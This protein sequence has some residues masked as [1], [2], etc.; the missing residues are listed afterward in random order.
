MPTM[1][2]A[3]SP[4]LYL[5]ASAID[6]MYLGTDKIYPNKVEQTISGS[7]PMTFTGDG[8]ALT[9]YRIHGYSAPVGSGSGV[10]INSNN[11]MYLNGNDTG[12]N[13]NTIPLYD[14]EY[15]DFEE[16]KV[17]QI[18]NYLDSSIFENGYYPTGSNQ[19][20]SWENRTNFCCNRVPFYL[21]A[22]RYSGVVDFTIETD[23]ANLG[24]N[25]AWFSSTTVS[26]S[27]GYR[28]WWGN[29]FYLPTSFTSMAGYP[30]ICLLFFKRNYPDMSA[31]ELNGH[32]WI[33]PTNLST[34]Y[35]PKG[36]L[37]STSITLPTLTTANGQNTLTYT[38]NPCT[39]DIT[40][41]V[42]QP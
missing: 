2:G 33:R 27:T 16:Q 34:G 13:L 35:V 10:I 42:S 9:N 15:A 19:W 5:G 28:A 39:M 31:S 40:G 1:I 20:K 7:L 8:S 38:A 11:I 17:Y 41:F 21:P 4:K 26:T 25:I 24:V 36:T 14:G 6:A 37:V 29:D 32:V 23:I 18:G 30:Y 12:I 3:N 22:A